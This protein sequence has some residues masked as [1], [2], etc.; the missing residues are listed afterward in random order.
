M[1]RETIL[2]KY[3]NSICDWYDVIL[4]DYCPFLGM[5]TLNALTAA[6]ELRRS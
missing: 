2:R 5:L 1:S 4:L 3:L 6:D